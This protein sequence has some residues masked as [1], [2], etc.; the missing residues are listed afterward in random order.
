M[1]QRE[2]LKCRECRGDCVRRTCHESSDIFGSAAGR[3]SGRIVTKSL[4]IASSKEIAVTG[5]SSHS[6]FFQFDLSTDTE[7]TMVNVDTMR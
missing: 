5:E 3:K 6:S 2:H 4:E 1:R 7:G